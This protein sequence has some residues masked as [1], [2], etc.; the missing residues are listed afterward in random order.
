MPHW[1]VCLVEDALDVPV[2]PLPLREQL[3]ELVLAEHRAQRGLGEL[4]GGFHV[5]LHVDAWRA[6]E[7]TTRKYSTAFTFTETL[8]RVMR[9]WVG[10]SMHDGAQVYPHHLT[11]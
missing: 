10:M 1:S 6:P 3:V 4:A 2:E 7:S 5:L 11:G 8:S 9:S